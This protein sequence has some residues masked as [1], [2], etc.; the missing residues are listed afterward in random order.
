[1][2]E[3]SGFEGS[4]LTGRKLNASTPTISTPMYTAD[5]EWTSS[6]SATGVDFRNSATSMEREGK[7]IRKP[8]MYDGQTSWEAYYAQFCIIADMS[9]WWDPGKAAFLATSLSAT[10][11]GEFSQ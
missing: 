1:M 6:Q 9:G 4:Q 3:R 2:T 10:S 7:V 8:N 11:F 5:E